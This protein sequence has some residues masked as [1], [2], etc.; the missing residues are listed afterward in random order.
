M[1]VFTLDITSFFVCAVV[2]SALNPRMVKVF[3]CRDRNVLFMYRNVAKNTANTG[4]PQ[5]VYLITKID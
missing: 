4:R 5:N 1:C 3:A 2:E